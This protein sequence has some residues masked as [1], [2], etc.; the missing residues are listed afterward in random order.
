[1]GFNKRFVREID[2][3][4]NELSEIGKEKFIQKYTTP[5]VLMGPSDSLAFINEVVNSNKNLKSSS[6]YKKQNN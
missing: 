3:L 4:K 6:K 5:D 2:F 1:M